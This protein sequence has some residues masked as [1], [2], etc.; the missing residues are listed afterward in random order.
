MNRREQDPA[1]TSAAS[2]SDTPTEPRDSE[3]ADVV[4]DRV[5][6]L[7]GS[8][9]FRNYE[10]V[11]DHV[12]QMKDLD[13][14]HSGTA[15][16]PSDYWREELENFEYMLDAHP[17]IIDK[18]RHH[19]H[20]VTGL[21]VYDYR[22]NKD[23]A[24][25][26]FA[27]KLEK[28]IDL[29]GRD[30]LV[31]EPRDM[32]GFGFEIDG[33]L[34]NIDTLKFYEVLIAMQRGGV[35]NQLREPEERKLVWEIG[36][37]W[38]G[39]PYQLKTLC[40][41]VTYVLMDFPELFLYSG[42][43]VKTLFP[44]ARV[45]FLDHGSLRDLLSQ[46]RDIDFLFVSNAFLEEFEPEQLDLAINMVSFQE[47][48]SEQVRAY[49]NK[50]HDLRSPYLYSL[51]RERSPYNRELSSV[52]D[53]IAERFWPHEIPVLPVSYTKMLNKIK[54]K[55]LKARLTKRASKPD[56]GYKHIVGWNR[57]ISS[58]EGM[59]ASTGRATPASRLAAEEVPQ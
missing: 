23:A 42:T 9:A 47:M 55:N 31:P 29:G 8:A 58:G 25:Q 46:W 10:Q 6:K 24:R 19:S 37:G 21:R 11:R 54:V 49:V 51:N 40:P 41:D 13:A 7:R 28:L 4:R 20:H 57:L 39:F 45:E 15:L 22:S 12:L 32:G 33:Q 2:M 3:Y 18:L 43:Y 56:T 16:E 30:L 38:G 52:S 44:E 59:A 35:L 14:R 50:A 53:V 5:D 26:L 27:Q 48:T 17:L 36:P 34:Y 1:S